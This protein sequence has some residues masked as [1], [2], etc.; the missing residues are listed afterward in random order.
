MEQERCDEEPGEDEEDV[1][2]Q[3]A[4]PRQS[5]VCGGVVVG[6]KERVAAVRKHND[7]D[8]YAANAVESGDVTESPHSRVPFDVSPVGRVDMRTHDSTENV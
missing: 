6:L 5:R 7:R 2:A 3:P 1:D 8:R 4:A